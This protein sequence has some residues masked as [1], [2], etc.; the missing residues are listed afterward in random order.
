MADQHEHDDRCHRTG[1]EGGG[2]ST[3]NAPLEAIDQNGVAA[4]I[5]NVH[6]EGDESRNL[7]VSHRAE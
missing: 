2:G 4:D 3:R 7:A 6:Q 1:N 5:D